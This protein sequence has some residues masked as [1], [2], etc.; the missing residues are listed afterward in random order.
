MLR[1]SDALLG[2]RQALEPVGAAKF[3]ENSD[4]MVQAGKPLHRVSAYFCG[5]GADSVGAPTCRGTL[6]VWA[7]PQCCAKSSLPAVHAAW[8]DDTVSESPH[9]DVSWVRAALSQTSWWSTSVRSR[10]NIRLAED[11]VLGP[12]VRDM[13]G[14]SG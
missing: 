13:W 12:V 3:L 5:R 7:W 14:Q 1:V 10:R 4:A 2:V 9:C 11:P 6:L 8:T